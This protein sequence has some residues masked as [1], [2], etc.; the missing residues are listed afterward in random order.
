MSFMFSIS[1]MV[2]NMFLLFSACLLFFVQLLLS[3]F[4][5][6]HGFIF[7]P[8]DVCFLPIHPC[9]GDDASRCRCRSLLAGITRTF[10][11]THRAFEHLKNGELRL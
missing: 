2:L 8:F 4:H 6:F 10:L 1:M 7:Q 5:H 11:A 9:P 3:V